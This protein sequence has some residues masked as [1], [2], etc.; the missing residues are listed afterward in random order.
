MGNRPRNAYL[1][2]LRSQACDL[3]EKKLDTAIISRRLGIHEQ[4]VRRWRREWAEQQEP[5]RP[6]E[7]N[8]A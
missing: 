7:G 3:F 1:R 6:G 2:V 4:V 8:S 5:N